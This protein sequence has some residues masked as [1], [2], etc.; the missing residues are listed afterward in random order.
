MDEIAVRSGLR[1]RSRQVTGKLALTMA[2]GEA[3]KNIAK[4]P[5]QAAMLLGSVAVGVALALAIIAASRGVDDK[6]S[7]L[8]DI[9]PMPPQIDLAEINRVLDQT[10]SLLTKLA[11]AFTAALVGTVT[12][13]SIGR[14]RR[15]IGIKRQY[16]LH[17]WEILAELWTEA[18]ILCVAGGL[19]GVALGYVLCNRLHHALPSLP[20]RSERGD[21][22]LVFPVVVVLSFGATAAVA[23]YFAIFPSGEPE[24]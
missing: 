7:G 23:S 6:V 20:M 14:R 3:M 4:R 18:T 1:L 10:R 12:W 17:V 22:L 13:L 21:I 15:E 8:L 11:F 5:G 24:L 2:A 19:A 16:G 9:R